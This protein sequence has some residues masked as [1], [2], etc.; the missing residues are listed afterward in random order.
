MCTVLM[1][2]SKLP[3]LLLHGKMSILVQLQK[4]HYQFFSS[5]LNLL[6]LLILC[7]NIGRYVKLTYYIAYEKQT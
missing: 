6:L 4:T 1:P 2:A 7:S 3:Q 5:L